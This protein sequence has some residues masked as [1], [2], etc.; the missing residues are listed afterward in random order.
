MVALAQ[1]VGVIA[2]ANIVVQ[3]A[4][5]HLHQDHAAMAVDD[6]LGQAGGAAGIHDP[7]RMVERQP[8]RLKLIGLC[9]ILAY[10]AGPIGA[11][12]Y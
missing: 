11:V 10:C 1:R 6:R 5:L 9:I 4:K 7:Q 2:A 8:Q 12:S 3:S